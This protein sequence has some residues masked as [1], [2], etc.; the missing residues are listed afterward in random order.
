MNQVEQYKPPPNCAK[1]S[2]K[3]SPGYVAENGDKSWELDALEPKVIT[4]LITDAVNGY[5]DQDK[6]QVRLEEQTLHKQ[7]L[8]Y[9][10]EHWKEIEI[11]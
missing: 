2:D 10:A 8:A 4:N 6:R 1:L 7:R 11:D 5:T 3:R 9:I